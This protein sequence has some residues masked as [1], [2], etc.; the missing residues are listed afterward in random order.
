M[1]TGSRVPSARSEDGSQR[2]RA[3]RQLADAPNPS[4]RA[5]VSLVVGSPVL[6]LSAY[7]ADRARRELG[8]D[9]A[10]PKPFDIDVLAA[11]VRALVERGPVP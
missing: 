6:I 9:D 5:S 1:G 10:L 4:I 2:R 3:S 11:R 7:G 8:A